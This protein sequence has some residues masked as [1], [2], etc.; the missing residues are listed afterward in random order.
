MQCGPLEPVEVQLE[1]QREKCVWGEQVVYKRLDV[2]GVLGGRKYT[3]L[4]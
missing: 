3:L 1:S 4:R 2:A